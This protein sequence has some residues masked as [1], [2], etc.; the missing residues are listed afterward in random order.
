MNEPPLDYSSPNP[1]RTPVSVADAV[2]GTF[3]ALLAGPGVAFAATLIA[4]YTSDDDYAAL[5]GLFIGAATGGLLTLILLA[6]G[7]RKSRSSDG[8]R[9]GFGIGL[10]IG[11]GLSLLS[12]GVCFAMIS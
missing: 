9:R 10:M 12:V 2:G 7:V 3:A 5:G 1:Q 11:A 4:E 6:V 8:R